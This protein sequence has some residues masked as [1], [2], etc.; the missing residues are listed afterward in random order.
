MKN[1]QLFE[2]KIE[3]LHG[4]LQQIRVMSSRNI[5]LQDLYKMLDEGE[6]ILDD[7]ANMIDRE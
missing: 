5:S 4:K 1:K 7:M 3:R 6:E 2:Q